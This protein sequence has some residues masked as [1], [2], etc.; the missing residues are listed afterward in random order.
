M[1]SKGVSKLKIIYAQ[2][3]FCYTQF[4][5]YTIQRNK[6][7]SNEPYVVAIKMRKFIERTELNY[8]W[9]RLNGT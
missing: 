5:F 9:I 8:I 4:K 3:L 6:Y 2:L 7:D 1:F